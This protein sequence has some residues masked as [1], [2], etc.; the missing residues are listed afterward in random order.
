MGRAL[1]RNRSRANILFNLRTFG[2]SNECS[3][4]STF[5]QALINICGGEGACEKNEGGG[6]MKCVWW[7][8]CR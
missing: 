6:V 4:V 8:G 5:V 1:I 3:N 2:N 7:R